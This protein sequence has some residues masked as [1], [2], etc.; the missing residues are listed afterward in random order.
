MWAT[1][2]A[3]PSAAATQMDGCARGVAAAS[4]HTDPHPGRRDC[5]RCQPCVSR[6]G[7]CAQKRPTGLGGW[8]SGPASQH[9]RRAAVALGGPLSR[10]AVHQPQQA[11]HSTSGRKAVPRAAARQPRYEAAGVGHRRRLPAPARAAAVGCGRR[12]SGRA[13]QHPHQS[14]LPLCSSARGSS[15]SPRR[16]R[17]ARVVPGRLRIRPPWLGSMSLPV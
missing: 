6:S 1:P 2:A 4:L 10:R 7:D 9:G 17:E 16:G 11:A 12:A 14:F 5:A 13:A 15:C 3:L 8:Q